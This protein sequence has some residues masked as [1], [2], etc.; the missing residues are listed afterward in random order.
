M[1]FRQIDRDGL[2]GAQVALVETEVNKKFGRSFQGR[3]MAKFLPVNEIE[4]LILLKNR[5]EFDAIISAN[6]EEL[7][8]IFDQTTSEK[9][10]ELGRKYTADKFNDD[11]ATRKVMRVEMR[12]DK[13]KFING[14]EVIKRYNEA[15]PTISISVDRYLMEL[16]VNSYPTEL[17]DYVGHIKDFFTT[18]EEELVGVSGESAS[19]GE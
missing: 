17:K 18:H 10:R 19:T 16:D 2:T 5:S 15:N 11:A 12:T 3:Y 4:N 9:L 8:D 1:I 7:G 13:V 6:T 14:K